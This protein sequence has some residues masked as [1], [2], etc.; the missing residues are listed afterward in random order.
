[1]SERKKKSREGVGG[2][3]IMQSGDRW[4]RKDEERRQST[5][6]KTKAGKGK[7]DNKKEEKYM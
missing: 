2:E 1:M 7:E 3:Q 5:R 6:M 4:R